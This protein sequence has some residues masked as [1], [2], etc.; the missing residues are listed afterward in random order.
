CTSPSD[1]YIL[2]NSSDFISHDLSVNTVFD[3]CQSDLS[4]PSPYRLALVL[5]R[6]SQRTDALVFLG[7]KDQVQMAKPYVLYLRRSSYARFT[8]EDIFDVLMIR[9]LSRGHVLDF[10]SYA[11]RTDPFLF[12]YE[13]LLSVFTQGLS[14]SKL[15]IVN[16]PL[17]PTAICNVPG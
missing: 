11:S 4:N 17:H 1:V 2:L 7:G 5:R 14:S 16:S 3:G 9:D 8:Y 10:N 13:E 12:T 15:H 6:C